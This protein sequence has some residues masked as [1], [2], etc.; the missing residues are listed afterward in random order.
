MLRVQRC[1]RTFT[2]QRTWA[3][4]CSGSEGAHFV[5]KALQNAWPDTVLTQVF[6]CEKDPATR[7]WNHNLVNIRRTALGQ[8]LVCIFHDICGLGKALAECRTHGCQC[9]VPGCDLLVVGTSREDQSQVNHNCNLKPPA[10]SL[11][12]SPGGAA[13]RFRGLLSYLDSHSADV[14]IYA[15]SDNLDPPSGGGKLECQG[16]A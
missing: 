13:T 5:M 12:A 14:V 6:A 16:E 3:S 11:L 4:A 2:G 7:K 10:L 15:N 8:D 1:P 9:R